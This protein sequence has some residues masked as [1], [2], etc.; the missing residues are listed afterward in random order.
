MIRS[1]SGTPGWSASVVGVSENARQWGLTYPALPER[2]VPFSLTSRSGAYL[3][4]RTEREPNSFISIVREAVREI[5][6]FIPVDTFW[7]MEEMVGQ[8]MQ[9]TRVTTLLIGLF[10]IIAV[11][12]ATAGTYGVES[13]RVA[14]RTQEIGIRIAF[15][16]S[17]KQ[18][19]WQFIKQGMRLTAIGGGVGVWCA[20]SLTII[21]SSRIFGIQAVQLFYLL[22]GILLL[23]GMMFLATAL[24]AMKATR[25]DP[26]DALRI[27]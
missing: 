3:V 4:M 13:F 6:P 23:A 21:L 12:L 14:Q 18:I 2:Y 20:I 22:A 25:G 26:M 9:G 8:Q 11:L 24:P 16:A 15:G 5:D 19:V 1:N 17:R 27:E 10:T 7:T